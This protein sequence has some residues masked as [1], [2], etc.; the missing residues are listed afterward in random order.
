MADTVSTQTEATKPSEQTGEWL[1][2]IF[3]STWNA[4]MILFTEMKNPE[5]L[6]TAFK[7]ARDLCKSDEHEFIVQMTFNVNELL[8]DRIIEANNS[9]HNAAKELESL[10]ND[11]AKLIKVLNT[12]RERV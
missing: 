4:G 8:L 7:S 10:G 3:L 6:R 11:I 12:N 1:K 5:I 2:E 9:D